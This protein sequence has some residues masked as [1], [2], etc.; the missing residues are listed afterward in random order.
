M[1]KIALVTGA[2]QGIGFGVVRRLCKE[3]PTWTVYG[4]S[5]SAANGEE[6]RKKLEAEGLTA[7]YLEADLTK[8]DTIVAMKEKLLKEHGGIDILVNNAG[9]AFKNTATDPYAVQ[10]EVTL[11]TNVFGTHTVCEQLF[12]ILRDGARVVILSSMIAPMALHK[13]KKICPSRYEAYIKNDPPMTLETVLNLM[14]EFVSSVKA[15]D[16]AQKGWPDNSAY[17]TSKL[18]NTVMARA[19]QQQFSSTP[20][21]DIVVNAADPGYVNTSMSSHKGPLTIDEGADTPYYLA[22]LPPN[23]PIKGQHVAKRKVVEWK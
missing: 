9:I 4:T 2:N 11:Q 14:R 6:A 19:Y 1:S 13:T 3:H 8:A 7:K 21:R 22:V 18:A 15:G 20:E 23:T 17:G 12:P 10:A 5:R 16:H